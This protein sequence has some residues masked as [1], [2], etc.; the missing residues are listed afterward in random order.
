MRK[1]RLEELGRDSLDTFKGKEKIALNL[2]LNDIRSALNVGSIFRTADAFAVRRIYLCGITARP[3]HKEINKTAIGATESVDWEY[4]EDIKHC[5]ESLKGEG[6]YIVGVEQTNESTLLNAF[7]YNNEFSSLTLVL[8]NE[9]QG[10]DDMLLP[11]LDEA[12]EIPQFGTKH[13]LNVSV[14]AGIVVWE[15]S[16]HLRKAKNHL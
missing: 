15:C 16:K 12:I 14:C 3:P 6:S 2:V 8:G 5:I 9:V 7:E 10:I 1:L 4:V 11:M 13:S